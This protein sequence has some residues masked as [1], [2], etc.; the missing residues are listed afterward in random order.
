M[1][2]GHGTCNEG[3]KQSSRRLSVLVVQ[4]MEIVVHAVI[5]T[6]VDDMLTATDCLLNQ[7][8]KPSARITAVN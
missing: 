2:S 6:K 7:I 4:S 1:V 3:D 5:D 8:P